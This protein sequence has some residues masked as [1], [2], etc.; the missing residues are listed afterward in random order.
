MTEAHNWARK[1]AEAGYEVF[2]L[3]GVYERDGVWID[4]REGVEAS[5]ELKSGKRPRVRWVHEATTDLAQVDEWWGKWP[6]SNVGVKCEGKLVVVDCDSDD[7]IDNF[8]L[9]YLGNEEEPLETFSV[10]TPRGCHF[11]F[12]GESRTFKPAPDTDVKA[13]GGYVVGPGSV[14]AGGRRYEASGDLGRVLDAPDWACRTSGDY[15]GQSSGGA[16]G[17]ELRIAAGNRSNALIK[18]A[19][20]LSRLGLP[21]HL[22]KEFVARVNDVCTDAPLSVAELEDTIYRSVD[23]WELGTAVVDSMVMLDMMRTLYGTT[24]D[25][26]EVQPEESFFMFEEDRRLRPEPTWVYEGLLPEYGIGQLFG[27][28]YVGKTFLGIDLALSL[29]NGLPWMGFSVNTEPR[30]YDPVMQDKYRKDHALYILGEGSW[31]FQERLDALLGAY[32][33]VRPLI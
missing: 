18:V 24:E 16:E 29:C 23:K 33:S 32:R 27:P 13:S 4:E 25:A 11:W 17:E 3:F 22:T 5:A 12:H 30:Y 6:H 15:H 21:R 10:V 8:E 28:S 31:D 1:L 2:P 26:D 7:A 14:S 20:A 9:S 19:G